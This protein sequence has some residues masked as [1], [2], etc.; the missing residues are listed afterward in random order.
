M[1]TIKTA[2]QVALQYQQN[3]DTAQ[4]E[5]IYRSVLSV[6][7][8][9]PDA[10]HLLGL[11]FHQQGATE[12]AISY[13]EKALEA[14]SKSFEGYHNSLGECYRVLG[15]IADAENQFEK[16]LALNPTYHASTFNLGLVHQQAGRSE[17]AL[18]LFRKVGESMESG[19]EM[20]E[21]RLKSKIRE[22]DLVN[23]L[24]KDGEA[25]SCWKDGVIKYPDRDVFYN[26]LGS[27]YLSPGHLNYDEALRYFSV[28]ASAGNILAGTNQAHVLETLDRFETSVEA[29][30]ALIKST[31]AQGLPVFHM[32]IKMATLLPRIIPHSEKLDEIRFNMEVMLRALLMEKD[33]A[34]DNA[35]AS[36]YGFSTGFFLIA[37]GV[38]N[39]RIKMVLA[40][41]YI[42]FCP[43]LLTGNFV[44]KNANATIVKENAEASRKFSEN[45]RLFTEL[46]NASNEEVSPLAVA[47]LKVETTEVMEPAS[48]PSVTTHSTSVAGF[49]KPS[50]LLKVGFASRFFFHHAVGI[51]A[52]G[53]IKML[54]HSGCEV[55]V[56]M[57]D[58]LKQ[59]RDAVTQDIIDS[60]H[61][62][63]AVN[64][65]LSIS[66]R[67][68]RE[69]Q[70]DILIFPE[71]G[72]DPVAYFLSF[73]H[74]AKVQVVLPGFPDTS[75]VPSADLYITSLVDA[76]NPTKF[77][78]EKLYRMHGLGVP[79]VDI[80]REYNEL[81]LYSPKVVA[82]EKA[83]FL[84]NL[85]L[86]Q[87]THVSSLL[88][89][90][91]KWSI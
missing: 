39:L 30:K 79:F 24:G 70:L 31:D 5:K 22:C 68:I 27:V 56:F 32:K 15:R 59:N 90:R 16:A 71:L 6:V 50:G 64:T 13:I 52:H 21:L 37:H 73:S 25:I 29:Y 83:V 88:S 80:H 55:I 3:G 53:L 69:A 11:V 42:R 81:L 10:L 19:E 84:A 49:R 23:L 65:D 58:G 45:D 18:A 72:I 40:R 76:P 26:E 46:D 60:A 85:Q 57:I 28:A 82:A 2:V 43:A 8:L 89:S 17:K 78:S 44:A 36:D 7:P 48:S 14:P 35:P 1:V 51:L 75:G 20:H 34:V 4:A 38:N 67:L 61:G 66:V 63:Y 33:V 86:P 77:H 74:L 9:Y 54:A 62:V 41:L 47:P 91:M 12:T 87:K